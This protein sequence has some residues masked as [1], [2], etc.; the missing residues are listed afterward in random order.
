MQNA[1]LFF[2]LIRNVCETKLPFRFAKQLLGV[3]SPRR[4]LQEAIST[5]QKTLYHNASLLSISKFNLINF[6]FSL[7]SVAVKFPTL[8]YNIRFYINIIRV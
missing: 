2:P 3:R 6:L 7:Y 5:E 8:I 1:K 4:S